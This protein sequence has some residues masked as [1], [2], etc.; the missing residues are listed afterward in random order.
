MKKLILPALLITLAFAANA[1]KID[2]KDVPA[3]VK[4]KFAALYPNVKDPKWE[5]E[6][7][8]YEAGFENGKE[9]ESS[10]VLDPKGN[11]LETEMGI[12]VS[13]LPKAITDYVAQHYQG[14]K[15]KGAAKIKDITG[16]MMYEAEIKGK[17]LI[18]DS[19]GKFL[20]EVK[21]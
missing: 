10:V 18:F 21:D 14:E 19:K 7:G 20:R 3:V 4:S 17:D 2:A 16:M 15:I 1:Q 8:N 5:K 6:K 12:P 9:G 11:M 13:Q